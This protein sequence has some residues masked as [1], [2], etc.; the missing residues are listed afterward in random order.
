MVADFVVGITSLHIQFLSSMH[1]L[2]PKASPCGFQVSR[3]IFIFSYIPTFRQLV[4]FQLEGQPYSMFH[5]L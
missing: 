3:L 2:S 1:R 5:Y 4:W